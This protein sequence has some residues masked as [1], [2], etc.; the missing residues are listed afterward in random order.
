MTH[1]QQL[2]V[3][4]AGAVIHAARN[5]LLFARTQRGLSAFALALAAC[6]TALVGFGVAARGV[7][8]AA[9]P[10][11]AAT[12]PGTAWRYLIVCDACGYRA[13]CAEH[14][15]RHYPQRRGL[16]RCPRCGEFRAAWYRRGSQNIPPGGW[17]AS[18]VGGEK[19]PNDAPPP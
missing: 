1:K 9:A 2:A 17:Y 4:W 7:W 10:P 3:N 14:P 15:A 13:R 16:L 5:S 19:G 18:D 11:P 8:S 6:A 12:E